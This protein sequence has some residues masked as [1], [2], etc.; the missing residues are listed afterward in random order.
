MLELV[1]TWLPVFNGFYGSGLEDDQD[2]EYTLFNN[3]DNPKMN[4]E[5]K[6]WLLEA[7]TDYICYSDY[8]K[9][10]SDA[11]CEGIS[12]ELKSHSLITNYKFEKLS[13][14]KYYNFSN[15]SIDVEFEVD[16]IH[17]IEECKKD[18]AEFEKYLKD[19]YT[20]YDGFM[21]SYSNDPQVWFG[22]E[23]D[24]TDGLIMNDTGHC[25]GS[26]LQFL[27]SGNDNTTYQDIVYEAASEVPIYDYLDYDKMLED[28]NDHFETDAKSIVDDIESGDVDETDPEVIARRDLIGQKLFNFKLV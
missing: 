23:D 11:I 25:I 3:P 27:L 18:L 12:E 7:V 16:I 8:C 4:E 13:S 19:H 28:F 6:N 17:L 24:Y 26:I 20:S 10:L 14:P 21:S 1:K 15:D 9:E 5:H 22:L 2:L